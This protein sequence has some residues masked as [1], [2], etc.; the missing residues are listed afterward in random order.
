MSAITRTWLA[1]AAFGAGLIH[2]A[3]VITSPLPVALVLIVI[4]AT[5][6]AWAVLTF[7]KERIAVPRVV[8]AGAVVPILLW[9]V[10]V[11]AAAV[12][13]SPA[14]ASYLG[15]S[16][17]GTATIFELFIAIVIAVHLRRGTDFSQSTRM[18]AAGRYLLGLGIGALVVGSI[19][20]PA[21]SA[22]DAGRYAKPMGDMHMSGLPPTTTMTTTGKLS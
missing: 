20:T 7:T 9:A 11:A 1:F 5:E 10:I 8:M 22:T 6:L 3:L 19:L 16:A 4:G 14:V 21:L 17:L 15:F 13:H 18:P 12:S 2:L